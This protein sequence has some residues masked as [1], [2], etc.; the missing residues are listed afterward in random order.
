[1]IRRAAAWL[2][3]R[4]LPRQRVHPAFL[5]ACDR[6][7]LE[8]LTGRELGPSVPVDDEAVELWPYEVPDHCW[9]EMA[10]EARR[11]EVKGAPMGDINEVL[12]GLELRFF[13]DGRRWMEGS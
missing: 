1:V 10:R 2:L 7:R 6:A 4:I 8:R 3:A 11:A 13:Q 12:A 9:R 5:A